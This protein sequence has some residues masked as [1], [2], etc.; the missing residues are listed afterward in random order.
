ME[1]D[2]HCEINE[3]RRKISGT[4]K[5]TRVG[6]GVLVSV[7]SILNQSPTEQ[8]KGIIMCD[9]VIASSCASLLVSYTIGS[10]KLEIRK[11]NL[12][13]AES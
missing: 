13:L 1:V 4:A 6:I 9:L 5:K 7:R 11:M 12:S 10:G 3:E 2:Q 8:F